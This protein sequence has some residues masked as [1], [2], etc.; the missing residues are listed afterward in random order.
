MPTHINILQ[1]DD[2]SDKTIVGTITYD[3]T[4][5]GILIAPAGSSFPGSPS[6]GEIFWRSD[7][8]ILYRRNDTNTTWEAINTAAASGPAG[9]DLDGYYPNPDVVDLTITGEVQGS[10]LYFD[11]SNWVQLPPSTS[12]LSLLTQ[13]IGSDPIWGAPAPGGAAGGD[14][15]GTYPNPT[16]TDLTIS[17]E[18]QGSILY[19]DGLNW[20]QLPPSTAGLALLTQGVGAD[21]IYG[22]PSPGGTAG[23]DLSG[24]YPN[25]TVIDLTISGEVQGSILYFNGT[26]WVQLSP[27]TVGQVLETQGVGANPVWADSEPDATIAEATVD[28]TTTSGTDVLVSG[29]T[30]TPVAGTYKVSFTGSV[31]VSVSGA[32]TFPSIYV[33]GVQEAS[34]ERQIQRTGFLGGTISQGFACEAIVTANGSQAIE[35]RIRTTAG[36][37]TI[38]ERTLIIVE[39]Q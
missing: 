33:G 35:G 22:A 26:N 1:I 29:M 9:G 28:T 39:V 24:I 18:V 14:L 3:R 12:G 16:V 34:S 6:A 32:I 8:D 37:A 10:V 19:F 21:P 23:G 20:V 31:E 30:L 15:S 5:G 27:G 38:H 17:G 2:S 4:N 13:G 25:P 7:Q 11:G 36:T